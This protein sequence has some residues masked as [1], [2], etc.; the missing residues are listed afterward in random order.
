MKLCWRKLELAHV[1]EVG[2]DDISFGGNVEGIG[3]GEGGGA[4]VEMAMNENMNSRELYR[5]I[6]MVLCYLLKTKTNSFKKSSK[7]IF[8]K[9]DFLS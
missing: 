7:T 8:T 2:D 4:N 6:M 1:G 3:N 9:H 5:K